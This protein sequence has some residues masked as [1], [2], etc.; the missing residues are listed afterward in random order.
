[1]LEPERSKA[2]E[3]AIE[4]LT[5]AQHR[6][7]DHLIDAVLAEKDDLLSC[8]P[9]G[10]PPALWVGESA[11]IAAALVRVHQTL[12]ALRACPSDATDAPGATGVCQERSHDAADRTFELFASLVAEVRMEEASRELSRVLQMPLDRAGTAARFF[13]RAARANPGAI[14]ELG[15]LCRRL[16][17]MSTAERTRLLMMSFG[18]QAVEARMALQVLSCRR[19]QPAPA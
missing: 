18:F 11:H 14:R 5:A 2:R 4:I 9:Q 10:S 8:V 19:P 6:F 15:T 16:E 3:Q 17:A 1:M 12:A 7:A 13:A